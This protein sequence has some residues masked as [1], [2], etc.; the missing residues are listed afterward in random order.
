[1]RLAGLAQRQ[2][3]PAPTA[4]LLGRALREARAAEEAAGLLREAQRRHP[5]DLWVNTHLATTLHALAATR[6]GY[7][8][9]VIGFLRV[10]VAL[11]PDSASAHSNLGVALTVRGLVDEAILSYRKAIRLREDFSPA[12][13]NLG[14]ALQMKG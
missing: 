3:V 12:H 4:V 11:R 13:L 14:N 7:R 9:E 2:E 10:A 1:R 6:P 5:A 8:D